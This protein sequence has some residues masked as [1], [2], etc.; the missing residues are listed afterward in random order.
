MYSISAYTE[1]SFFAA[2]ASLYLSLLK[3]V[4]WK[5]FVGKEQ[6]LTAGVVRW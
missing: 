4:R 6:E 1:D 2:A 3:I 5:E